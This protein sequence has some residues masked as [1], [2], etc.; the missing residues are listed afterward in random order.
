MVRA[1]EA[2]TLVRRL[3]RARVAVLG[4]LVADEYVYGETDRV[5]REAPVLVVRHESSETK[6]GGAANAA[7]NVA[8]LGATV[9]P[10]GV[11]GQDMAGRELIKLFREAGAE[12]AGVLALAGRC[13]ETK[14]R[15]LAGGRSTTRQQMLRL[16]RAEELPLTAVQR[17]RVLRNLREACDGADALIVSDYG[18][19]L[20]DE[21]IRQEIRALAKTLPVC[22]DS[23]YD[24]RAW[25]GVTLAK[26]NELELETA[27][28]GRL[29][30]PQ[31]VERAGRTLLAALEVQALVVTRGRN[32]M[33]L[34]TPDAPTL[35]IPVFGP[36]EVVDVTGAGDTVLAS[37]ACGLAVGASF[38][39]AARLANVA[40]GLVVQKPGTATISQQELL[41][42]LGAARS[43][44]PAR[45]ANRRR[46]P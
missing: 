13:T 22:V 19:G 9:R 41:T 10:I 33:W 34:F 40:G 26:P 2:A 37:L 28:G 31:D 17:R 15:I 16:D 7:A 23:R 46:A 1:M 45:A 38:A 32:G 24:L 42:A 39:D 12:V 14:T 20:V 18:S 27:V 11:V 44:R 35:H 8:A 25:R 36:D 6:L 30:G 4:D 43:V 29:K 3:P 21:K 5:S